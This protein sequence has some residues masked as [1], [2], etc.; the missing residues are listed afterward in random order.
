VPGEL[1]RGG[2]DEAVDAGLG[3]RVLGEARIAGARAGDDDV[4]T[5]RP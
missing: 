2:A 4:I 3:R 1:D 5:I